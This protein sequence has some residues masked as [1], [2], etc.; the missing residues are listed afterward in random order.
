M[1][2]YIAKELDFYFNH[3]AENAHAHQASS[4]IENAIY[5]ELNRQG[6]VFYNTP[7]IH[8]G[9]HEYN[10]PT[11]EVI[12]GVPSISRYFLRQSA[13]FEKQLIVMAGKKPYFQ[14]SFCFR[15]GEDG[16]FHIPY[17]NQIDLE[18]PF[19][20]NVTTHLEARERVLSV[21]LGLIQT[22]LAIGGKEIENVARISYEDSLEIHG[23]DSPYIA[24]VKKNGINI[25]I[26]E[27][28]PLL[29]NKEGA[30]E[31]VV[32]PM[33]QPIM[34]DDEER[35]F[36]SGEMTIEEIKRIKVYGYDIIASSPD[37]FQLGEAV[38]GLEISGGSVRIK[39]PDVQKKIVDLT[40][41]QYAEDYLPLIGLLHHFRDADD[42]TAGCAV[43]LERLVMSAM[44][45]ADV[46]KALPLPWRD[47]VPA[48][49]RRLG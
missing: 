6:F 32:H 31:T 46:K 34:T 21:A 36:V 38:K 26:V 11:A 17:H 37:M 19:H 24:P 29:K 40:L 41:P 15:P 43:G 5:G 20:G 39:N 45:I 48:F 27:N 8:H 25:T 47:N 49:G 3:L 23:N 1:S 22:S 44:G 42:Y 16:K 18:L 28:P 2:D 30:Y 4:D 35:R 10:G 9:I 33:A 7:I 14:K 13:Q 12:T